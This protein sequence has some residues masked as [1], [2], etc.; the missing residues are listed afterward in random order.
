M[1]TL[2]GDGGERGGCAGSGCGS[3]QHG[4]AAE[5]RTGDDGQGK[6]REKEAGMATRMVTVANVACS[7]V[8]HLGEGAVALLSGRVALEE[9]TV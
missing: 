8:A 5:T 1:E 4:E 9:V 7:D 6:R 3:C 2:T